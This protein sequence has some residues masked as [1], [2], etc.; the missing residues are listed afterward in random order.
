MFTTTRSSEPRVMMYSQDGFGLGHM[1]RTTSIATQFA[2]VRSDAAL[3]TLA[4]SRLGRS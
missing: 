3:M 1:R 2:R 4:N